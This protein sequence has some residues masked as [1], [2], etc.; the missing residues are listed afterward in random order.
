MAYTVIKN[1]T[2]LAKCHSANEAK[3]IA[4]LKNGKVVRSKYSVQPLPKANALRYGDSPSAKREMYRE[5]YGEVNHGF[6]ATRITR[7]IDET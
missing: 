5:I 6:H 7:Q 1:N 2:A 4:K 3:R